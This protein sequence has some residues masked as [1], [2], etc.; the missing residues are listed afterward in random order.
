M[1]AIT[2]KL[3]RDAWHSRGQLG[4]IALVVTA[5]MALFVSLRSMH[6][7]LREARD[8][9]YR[10]ARFGD[11]FAFV[12][13]APRAILG[14]LAAVPG[15]RE[16]EARLVYDVTLDV[17]GLDEPATGRLVS[18]PVPRAPMLNALTL[19]RGR[20]PDPGHHDEVIISQAFAR[21]NAL[22]PGDSLGAVIN[23]TWRTLRVVGTAISPE[24]V[25][26]IGAA[27]I[28]PDN[29]RFG[30]LWMDTD[31]V[32][33]AFDMR[34]AFN[35]VTLLLAPQ[36][37]VTPA[38]TAV[39]TLLAPFGGPGAFPRRDQ[40]SDQFLSGEIEETQ[41]T[42]ILLPAIFLGVTAFL[43][44]IVLSRLVG[45]QREQVAMLKAFGYRDATIAAHYLALALVPIGVGGV[46]GGVLGAALADG[47]AEVYAR[48]FQFP[49]AAYRQDP[50]VVVVGLAITMGAGLAG[51]M[52][53]VRRTVAL[54]PAEAM[55]PEAP[56]R[57]Q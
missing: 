37:P 9:Y 54:P 15:I 14:D 34:G 17:P 27:S 40:L 29:R 16:V 52:R 10:E 42:S 13:R 57:Y 18:V 32:A 48:F 31:A 21:A 8:T 30:V 51:A 33:A 12:S 46:V 11:A 2:R 6:G 39:D 45:T 20:W 55:R 1:R 25:Y 28:F 35:A 7:Y 50:G 47:L 22:A 41:V 44:H 5:G 26:E 3:W 4:A 53:A 43:L 38:L 23:G 19:T 49:F 56:A 24:Y 36:A